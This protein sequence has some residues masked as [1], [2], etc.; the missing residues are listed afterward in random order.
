MLDFYLIDDHQA[1]FNDPE[2]AG[3]VLAG[4]IERDTFDRLKRIRVIDGR[5]A[6][7]SDF[8]WSRALIA[9]MRS[10]ITARQIGS[11]TDVQKLLDVLNLADQNGSGLA[12]FAD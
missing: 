10:T 4:H 7:D 1:H 12:A 8:R 6:Y 11:S 9:E 3:L 5:F 2:R